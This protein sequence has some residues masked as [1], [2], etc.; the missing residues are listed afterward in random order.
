M[1]LAAEDEERLLNETPTSI[2][3]GRGQLPEELR[4]ELG[5]SGAVNDFQGIF[6][7]GALIPPE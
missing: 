5:C 7:G 1:A 3:D 6:S 2:A 4:L